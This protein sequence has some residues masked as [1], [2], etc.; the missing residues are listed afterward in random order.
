MFRTE[1]VEKIKTLILFSIIFFSFE[2]RIVYEKMW[3]NIVEPEK[4]QIIVWGMLTACCMPKATNT[5]A[6][7]RLRVRL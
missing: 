1:V 6:R 3:K 4:P 2:N 7:T 5:H